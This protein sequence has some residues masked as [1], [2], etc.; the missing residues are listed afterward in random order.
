MPSFK[1]RIVFALLLCS[2]LVTTTLFYFMVT[3]N[4]SKVCGIRLVVFNWECHFSFF[5]ANQPLKEISIGFSKF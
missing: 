3:F 1:T 5:T 4:D 2:L